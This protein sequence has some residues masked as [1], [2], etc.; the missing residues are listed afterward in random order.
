M[1]KYVR[2]SSRAEKVD[3]TFISY[4]YTFPA[5]S[6]S[7]FNLADLDSNNVILNVEDEAIKE[8][9]GFVEADSYWCLT[10]LLDGIQD[11][12]TFSQPG[13]QR[14]VTRLKALISRIDGKRIQMD[15]CWMKQSSNLYS[16]P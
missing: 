6:L 16:L 2:E 3:L 5:C 13:I 9:L 15:R 1:N 14:Q 4:I 12:Y 7:L 10:K 8:K 11:N